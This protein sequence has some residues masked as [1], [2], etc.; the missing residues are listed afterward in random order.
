[1]P[2]KGR[3]QKGESGNPA[4][5]TPGSPDRRSQ[6]RALIDAEAPALVRLAVAQA[7]AGDS[8]ALGLLLARCVAPL[9]PESGRVAFD[10]P[11][12]ASLADQAR[13]VLAAIAAGRVDPHTG[14]A[15]VDAVAATARVIEADEIERRLTALE[16]GVSE[17]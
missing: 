8:Q 15:M 12:G 10:F 4:G 6:L 14:R 7:L 2:R 5:R 17:P 3:W 1:M 11:A 16:Q 13:A 9:R